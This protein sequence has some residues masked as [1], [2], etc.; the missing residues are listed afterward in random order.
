MVFE[1]LFCGLEQEFTT[2][3]CQHKVCS[4][5]LE[6][7]AP[8][9][10]PCPVSDNCK[11]LAVLKP[12]ETAEQAIA[13]LTQELESCTTELQTI[14]LEIL[15]CLESKPLY[16]FRYY[17]HNSGKC[18]I[19]HYWCIGCETEAKGLL[20]FSDRDIIMNDLYKLFCTASVDRYCLSVKTDTD[21]VQKLVSLTLSEVLPVVRR[22]L[23][24]QGMKKMPA[25]ERADAFRHKGFVITDS[26]GLYMILPL[27]VFTPRTT[28][29]TE[30]MFYK[31]LEKL[32][33]GRDYFVVFTDG[34]TAHFP[35]TVPKE[36]TFLDIKTGNSIVRSGFYKKRP[37]WKIGE[38]KPT[39]DIRVYRELKKFIPRQTELCTLIKQLE[40]DIDGLVN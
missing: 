21:G 15:R 33:P 13:R 20:C 9:G 2:L 6:L 3:P 23:A 29:C 7:L 18:R 17:Y 1:C 5:C 37:G 35:S 34:K 19:S 25:F 40:T 10:K 8:D 22:F 36:C 38:V 14:D 12:D 24:T 39:R 11:G 31:N 30:V 28:Y 16:E 4:S 26:T 27:K 32:V